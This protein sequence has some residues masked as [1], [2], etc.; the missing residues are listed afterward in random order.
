MSTVIPATNQPVMNTGTS[1]EQSTTPMYKDPKVW[2]I[3]A[4]VIVALLCL[5]WL[6]RTMFK[7]R[8]NP[9]A[10]YSD[11]GMLGGGCGN[12]VDNSLDVGGEF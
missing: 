12:I 3:A 8:S 2:G 9:S 6:V 7:R 11:Y 5:I 4:G 1:S 10:E